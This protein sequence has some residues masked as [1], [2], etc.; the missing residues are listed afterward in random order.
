MPSERF[1]LLSAVHLFLFQADTILLL[2]RCNTGFE[3][4]N[5][6]VVAGHLD[7]GETVTQAAVR[8]AYEEAGISIRTEDL[9][10]VHVMHQWIKGDGVY[11]GE[12]RID[13]FV[14]ASAWEGAPH[15]MEPDKCDELAWHALHR[16]PAN[17]VPYV[18]AALRHY[19]QGE[20]F[21]EFGW[22]GERGL[23]AQ[24]G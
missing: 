22:D 23:G 14:L 2:R 8:E 21:S 15:N 9:R 19:Q 20:F 10:V 13:F 12:E 1:R 4:G 17:M 3:D 7:G 24:T 6:S 16:L 11:S 5:Y 18:A